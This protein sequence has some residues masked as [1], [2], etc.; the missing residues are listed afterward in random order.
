[1]KFETESFSWSDDILNGFLGIYTGLML[2][3]VFYLVYGKEN[4]ERVVTML[5]NCSKG[6]LIIFLN[7]NSIWSNMFNSSALTLLKYI[8]PF[9]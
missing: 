3:A 7:I 4:L 1:M 8:L 5:M 9:F 6:V 2:P